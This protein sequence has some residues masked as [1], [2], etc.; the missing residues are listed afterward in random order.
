MKNK[1]FDC[2]E[3]MHKGADHVRK[4]TDG[5]TLKEELKFWQER[6][7]DLKKNQKN[8]PRNIKVKG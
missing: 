5:Y 7:Q 2:V 6:S 4:Q 1:K 3:M 8:L